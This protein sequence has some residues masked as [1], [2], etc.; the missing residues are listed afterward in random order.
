LGIR[1]NAKGG[2]DEIAEAEDMALMLFL[3][4]MGTLTFSLKAQ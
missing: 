2:A 4:G 3:G 1:A